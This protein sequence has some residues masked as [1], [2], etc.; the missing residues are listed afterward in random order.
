VN[1][2][3]TLG[4]IGLK[5]VVMRI[6]AGALSALFV[7]VQIFLF[8]TSPTA[9][10]S[11]DAEKKCRDMAIKVHLQAMPGKPYAQTEREFFRQCVAK[12]GQIEDTDAPKVLYGS[13]T[14][15]RTDDVRTSTLLQMES[16]NMDRAAPVLIRIYKEENTLEV[17]KSDRTGKFALLST[18]P[19]CKYSGH[20]G[21][22]IFEGDHQTPEG[23]YDIT[24]DQMKSDRY[25]AFN[26]GFPNAFDRSLGRTGSFLM[27]HGGCKSVGCY[28]MMD[29]AMDEIYGLVDEAFR[30]GQEKV[31]LEAF[32]FR[33]TLQNLARHADDPNTPFWEMLK[34]GSDAFLTTG[35][36]PTIAVCDERY[37]F[38][39]AIT[40]KNCDL[41]KEELK[42]VASYVPRW[43]VWLAADVEES[44]AWAIYR[45]RQ[46]R[47]ASLIGDRE[48]IVLLRQIPG[49]GRA[50]R[51]VI[52]IADD[53][54]TPLDQLCKKLNAANT[55]CDVLRNSRGD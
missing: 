4:G 30:G 21:P 43:G 20:L 33:M 29:H 13:K 12:N 23:F 14:T 28:A 41:V 54:R 38:N 48:P 52:T 26:I 53:N 17:W 51:Y 3:H 11:V 50:K 18:Y 47:F 32:P 19:I 1:A 44:K 7:T 55:T 42:H 40:D 15:A 45:E 27:V 22:K 37:V 36:P 49:M 39:A 10:I 8:S 46:K 35:R 2:F 16:L 25:L 5:Q 31:Q 9:A 24:P 6:T 34:T